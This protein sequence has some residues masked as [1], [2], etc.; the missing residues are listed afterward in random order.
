MK[1]LLNTLLKSDKNLYLNDRQ[2]AI[3]Y[4]NDNYRFLYFEGIKGDDREG[5]LTFVM[6]NPSFAGQGDKS[7]PTV[8]RLRK[9]TIN[10]IDENGRKYKYF[11]VI[12]TCPYVSSNP[13]YIK[14]DYNKE[15]FEFIKSYVDNNKDKIYILAYGNNANPLNI[16]E[17][18]ALLSGRIGTFYP[19]L[20]SINRPYHPLVRK[21]VYN[22]NG[23]LKWY[24][25]DK[26]GKNIK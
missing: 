2:N 5:V 10:F 6:C 26:L 19:Q 9:W 20:S 1:K 4:I 14:D 24:N 8:D 7:D 23:S 18:R 25:V 16:T 21:K 11:A 13:K 17:V 22:K 15:N 3:F 12:N